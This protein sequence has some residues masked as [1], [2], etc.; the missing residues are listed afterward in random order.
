MS[1]VIRLV[2]IA[3]FFVCANSFAQGENICVAGTQFIKKYVNVGDVIP[4]GTCHEGCSAIPDDSP[5]GGTAGYC[6]EFSGGYC[7]IPHTYT[8]APCGGGGT[9]NPGSGSGGGSDGGSGSGS[10]DPTPNP[11]GG[12]D[13]GESEETPPESGEDGGNGETP[14]NDSGGSDNDNNTPPPNEPGIP[15]NAI[16]C[17]EKNEYHHDCY[18]Y[19]DHWDEWAYMDMDE[20]YPICDLEEDK[21]DWWNCFF[22]GELYRDGEG[23]KSWYAYKK[24]ECEYEYRHYGAIA[25]QYCA[26]R[27]RDS[28][29]ARLYDAAMFGT[30]NGKNV[31]GGLSGNSTIDIGKR[32][33]IGKNGNGSLSSTIPDLLED[34][35][36]DEDGEFGVCLKDITIEIFGREIVLHFSRVCPWLEHLGTIFLFLSLFAA[37]RI[38]YRG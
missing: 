34:D 37:I 27:Y 3:L 28:N 25:K 18:R 21:E 32:F 35:A 12:S 33:G 9:G 31:T 13:G 22:N 24:D 19:I 16:I 15:N 14:G 2:V 8:G 26:N 4:G 5:D 29:E 7:Y 6:E 20:A 11:G 38:I 10:D 23:W 1:Y 36:P 17:N 30:L